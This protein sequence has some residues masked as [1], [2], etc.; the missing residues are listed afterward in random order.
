M[1]WTKFIPSWQR[2]SQCLVKPVQRAEEHRFDAG[3]RNDESELNEAAPE[4]GSDGF[5]AAQDVQLDEDAAQMAL[6]VVSLMAERPA[7]T[8]V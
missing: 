2:W 4:R 7:S 3:N 6:Y 1:G 5:G 8:V